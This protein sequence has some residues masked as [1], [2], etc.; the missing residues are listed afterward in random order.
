LFNLILMALA[1]PVRPGFSANGSAEGYSFL[2]MLSSSTMIRSSFFTRSDLS[3]LLRNGLG[4]L[5]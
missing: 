5:T 4:G 2:I 3:F 1:F